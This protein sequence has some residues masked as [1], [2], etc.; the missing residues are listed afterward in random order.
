MY[1]INDI[2]YSDEEYQKRAEFCNKNNLMIVEL[3]PDENGRRFQIQEAPKPSDKDN[4][5][6]E[7]MEAKELL[8]KY[9]EDVEQVDLFGMERADY[10]EKKNACIDLVQKLRQLEK[11]YNL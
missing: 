2:F 5:L 3:E 6:R 8:N 7:I 9:R 11:E 4:L 10:N 1:N